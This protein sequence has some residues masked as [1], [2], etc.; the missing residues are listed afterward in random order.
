[1]QLIYFPNPRHMVDR[2]V[3]GMQ[4]TEWPGVDCTQRAGRAP[5]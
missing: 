4:W 2:P 3:Q 5:A 1:M